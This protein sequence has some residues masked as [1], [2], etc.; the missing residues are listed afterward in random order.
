MQDRLL[1]GVLNLFPLRIREMYARRR[2]IFFEML[3]G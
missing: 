2:N 3:D 1:R